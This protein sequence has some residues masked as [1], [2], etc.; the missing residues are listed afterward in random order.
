[1][2]IFKRNQVD[3]WR[4]VAPLIFKQ[5][6]QTI[7]SIVI[8]IVSSPLYFFLFAK[9]KYVISVPENFIILV[10]YVTAWKHGQSS[11]GE[12]LQILHNILTEICENIIHQDLPSEKVSTFLNRFQLVLS[13]YWNLSLIPI[14]VLWGWFDRIE[15][16]LVFSD[17]SIPGLGFGFHQFGTSNR[18]QYLIPERVVPKPIFWYLNLPGIAKC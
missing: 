7:F 1:M 17:N 5:K 4:L 14:P 2:Y 10:L 11:M 3:Q 13:R 9:S 6:C 15:Q 16:A 18:V 12:I 8:L